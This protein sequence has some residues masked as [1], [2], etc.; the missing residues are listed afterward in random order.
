[1]TESAGRYAGGIGQFLDVLLALGV[2][3]RQYQEVLKNFMLKDLLKCAATLPLPRDRVA[4]REV[5]GLPAGDG[6]Y[7][8]VSPISECSVTLLQQ[9]MTLGWMQYYNLSYERLQILLRSDWL[10]WDL[11]ESALRGVVVDRARV[12]KELGLP[13]AKLQMVMEPNASLRSL[14]SGYIEVLPKNITD[15]FEES[16]ASHVCNEAVTLSADFVPVCTDSDP[17][18]DTKV[19]MP[20]LWEVVRRVRKNKY[21][22]MAYFCQLLAF[23]KQHPWAVDGTM[24]IAL[25]SH[26]YD[27]T[28]RKRWYPC[29]FG[30]EEGLCVYPVYF[31]AHLDPGY[32]IL[33]FT[34]DD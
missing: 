26:V 6:G 11:F 16:H 19:L 1:M 24:L 3:Q 20:P 34:R 12:R 13:P 18:A 32:R 23:C 14:I 10:L 8:S 27:K 4:W 2:S 25:G 5:L 28:M 33:A 17:A 30:A 31:D 21:L 7:P 15:L 9:K 29:V 22:R